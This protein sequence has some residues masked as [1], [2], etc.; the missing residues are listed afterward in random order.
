[1]DTMKLQSDFSLKIPIQRLWFWLKVYPQQNVFAEFP[2][3]EPTENSSLGF[4]KTMR[5]LSELSNFTTI[6]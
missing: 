5:D 3:P 1:M 4:R 6:R 2:F